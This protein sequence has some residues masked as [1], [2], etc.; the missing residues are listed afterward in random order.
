[1]KKIKIRITKDATIIHIAHDEVKVDHAG[2]RK[3]SRAS[4]V[5][6]WSGLRLRAR[7]DVRKRHPLRVFCD[8][9]WFA[10]LSP[11]NGPVLGPFAT[12]KTALLAEEQWLVEK[13]FRLN[14]RTTIVESSSS[15][16]KTE[17]TPPG[18]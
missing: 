9:D 5:E 6:P 13:F 7:V 15:S 2:P 10:D 11:V 14:N 18:A 16:S 3:T 4:H 1:M 17:N 12:R 8:D